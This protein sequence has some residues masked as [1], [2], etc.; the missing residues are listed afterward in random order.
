MNSVN[1]DCILKRVKN[2]QFVLNLLKDAPLATQWT[3]NCKFGVH[4]GQR[5]R[6]LLNKTLTSIF[7]PCL[8]TFIPSWLLL[9]NTLILYRLFQSFGIW[10]FLSYVAAWYFAQQL[11]HANF[12]A[13]N[14]F[15]DRFNQRLVTLRRVDAGKR[16]VDPD[17][18]LQ[19]LD[20]EF[21]SGS[22]V[23]RI[24]AEITGL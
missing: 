13:R 8:I 6:L 4:C 10:S 20:H 17:A 9:T 3:R 2:F 5:M 24:F 21:A 22:N 7:N 18:V 15:L 16:S 14:G 19:E 11:G 23:F 1:S 12:K